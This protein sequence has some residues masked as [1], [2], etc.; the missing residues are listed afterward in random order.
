MVLGTYPND[1][2]DESDVLKRLSHIEKVIHD[3]ENRVK[4][5]MNNFVISA[6]IYNEHITQTAFE[7]SQRIGKV[8]VFMGQTSCKVPFGPDY[9]E[10]VKS[11]N[12]IGKKR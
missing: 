9:I 12:R 2:I 10:K 5:S 6:G 8:S 1:E 11:M 7:I 3:E 4:Y